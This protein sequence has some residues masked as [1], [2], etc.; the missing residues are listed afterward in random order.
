MEKGKTEEHC[1]SSKTSNIDVKFLKPKEPKDE[2]IRP[3]VFD[4]LR[5]MGF[6]TVVFRRKVFQL[7]EK[8]IGSIIVL[9]EIMSNYFSRFLKIFSKQTS[10]ENQILSFSPKNIC[11]GFLLKRFHEKQRS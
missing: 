10:Q 9:T 2:E 3:I 6:R 8:E 4:E 5:K 7:T 11:P 1:Y